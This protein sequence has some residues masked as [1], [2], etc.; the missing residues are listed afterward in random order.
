MLDV[1]IAE[2]FNGENLKIH[3][4]EIVSIS[5]SYWEKEK[6]EI[7]NEDCT[8]M[9]HSLKEEYEDERMPDSEQMFDDTL[10]LKFEVLD[11]VITLDMGDYSHCP[12]EWRGCVDALVKDFEDRFSKS[13]LD[14]EITDK[15]VA[16]FDF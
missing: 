3:Y 14:L 7:K 1:K 13:K 9:T 8:L 2:T 4:T 10:E 5:H 16:D 6:V 15:Y 11:K 12:R